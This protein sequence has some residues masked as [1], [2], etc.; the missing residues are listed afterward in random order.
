M[1]AS[2]VKTVQKCT[3][4]PNDSCD[5]VVGIVTSTKPLTIKVGNK[6][7]SNT[8]LILSPFCRKTS[9]NLAHSHSCPDGRTSTELQLVQLWR[10]LAVNDRVYMLNCNKGQ[11]YYV[12]QRQ[13]GVTV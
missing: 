2:F 10:G 1:G 9:V 6:S 3:I 11:K 8:F 12:L 7:I 5:L 13:E 4:T